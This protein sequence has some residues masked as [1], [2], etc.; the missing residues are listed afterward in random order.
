M[1][2]YQKYVQLMESQYQFCFYKTDILEACFSAM[3]NKIEQFANY[4]TALNYSWQFVKPNYSQC[5]RDYTNCLSYE[6]FWMCIFHIAYLSC[7]VNIFS[8]YA[9][10]TYNTN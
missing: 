2:M 6:Q 8:N 5:H 1:N 7:L 10:F 3:Q 9:I 4:A